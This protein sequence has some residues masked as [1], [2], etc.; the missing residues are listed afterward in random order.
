MSGFRWTTFGL[1]LAFVVCAVALLWIWVPPAYDTNDDV[2]IRRVLEG[3]RVPGQPPTGFALLP[4]AALGWSLVALRDAWPSAYAWDIAVTGIL[5]WGL[6]VFLSLVWRSLNSAVALQLSAAIVAVTALLPLVGSVQ[7]TISA[8]IAGGAAILL[9]WSELEGD[10]ARRRTVLAMA[11]ALLVFGLL[12][13]SGGA[14]AGAL[15]V[16]ACLMPR[17]ILARRPGMRAMAGLAGGSVALAAVLYA[18]DVALYK[19]RPEW[20]AYREMNELVTALFD[21]N[22]QALLPAAVDVTGTRKSVGWT[23]SDWTMLEHAWAVTPERFSVGSVREFYE[24]TLA[25]LTPMDYGSAAV[26]R[27]WMFDRANWLERLHEA[28]PGLLGVAIVL[29]VYSQA[30]DRRVTLAAV[31]FFAAYCLGVQIGFKSLPFRLLAPMFACF[32]SVLLSTARLRPRGR[33]SAVLVLVAV[34]LLSVYQARAVF[35]AMAANHR[36]SLQVDAEGAAL[37]ALQPS[38]VVIHRDRFPEEHWLRP[39]HTPS[40]RLLTIR[41][42]R[43]NQNPQLLSFFQ[44]SGLSTFPSAICD[45][46]SILVVS[47]PGRLDVLTTDLRERAGRSVIWKPVFTGSFTAWQCLPAPAE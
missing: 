21:W 27:L 14:L 9:A 30:R 2:T 22:W 10:G 13:R 7:Y 17:A 32:V 25:H 16:I 26:Q 28:W 45:D 41:L 46:P 18:A 1:S 12:L 37:A 33:I 43:N 44:G 5:V 20:D 29:A 4:H 3:T 42:G 40:V 23:A 6:A 38:L 36:H 39:F 15:A 35:A 34:L 47:E 8:T 19:T 24:A 31:L 11:V